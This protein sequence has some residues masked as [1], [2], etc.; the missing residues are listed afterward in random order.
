MKEYTPERLVAY[1]KDYF[2]VKSRM[3]LAKELYLNPETIKHIEEK[4]LALSSKHLL[5]IH[6]TSGIS[7]AYLRDLIGDTSDAPYEPPVG[8]PYHLY[9]E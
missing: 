4:R 3:Q 8:R 1:L 2:E 7:V 9:W 5:R 6:E